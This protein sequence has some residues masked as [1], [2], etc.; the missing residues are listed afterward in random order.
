MFVCTITAGEDLHFHHIKMESEYS[1]T[2]A[3][4]ILDGINDKFLGV[5]SNINGLRT[6]FTERINKMDLEQ[7]K[8]LISIEATQ[9]IAN[10]SVG[11]LKA[12]R[13]GISMCI[14][15][16]AFIV[17]P[18]IVYTFNLSVEKAKQDVLL[19]LKK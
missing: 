18:L 3:D 10:G 13:T 5:H 12:W 9:K 2:K 6:E 11:N 17:L 1:K 16:I 15:I 14:A 7:G 8:A 19:E 4:I